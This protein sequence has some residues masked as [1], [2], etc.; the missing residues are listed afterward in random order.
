MAW[1][2]Q[3]GQQGLQASPQTALQNKKGLEAGYLM[4]GL[5]YPSRLLLQQLPLS[6]L[7]AAVSLLRLDLT[8]P[9][10]Q[11]EDKF[12]IWH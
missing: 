6:Q 4:I 8:D 11:G 10:D 7:A 12:S 2:L 3:A 1:M 9:A 5:L